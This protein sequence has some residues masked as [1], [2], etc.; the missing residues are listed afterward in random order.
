M[1]TLSSLPSE[2]IEVVCDHLDDYSVKSLR[3]SNRAM[4]DKYQYNFYK[5]FL[6]VKISFCLFSV[7]ALNQLSRD[8]II[9]R[10]IEHITIGTERLEQYIPLALPR[11]RF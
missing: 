6:T 4:L 8:A 5:L 1:A 7:D 11:A 9:A 10:K 3:Q 2:L